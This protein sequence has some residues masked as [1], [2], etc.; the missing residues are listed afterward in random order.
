MKDKENLDEQTRTEHL[1]CTAGSRDLRLGAMVSHIGPRNDRCRSRCNYYGSGYR[2]HGHAPEGC[3]CNGQGGKH[4]YLPVLRCIG[5]I[6]DYGVE[7]GQLQDFGY[8]VWI[9]AEIGGQGNRRGSDGCSVQVEADL[10]SIANLD[11][12]VCLGIR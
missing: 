10:E 5:E 11:C 12:R 4:K 2:G 9:R 3:T 1:G 6:P 8:G 7:T